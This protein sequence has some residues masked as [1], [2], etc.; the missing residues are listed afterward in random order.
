[1]FRIAEVRVTPILISDPPLL[2][3]QGVHQPVHAP[4]DRRG[5]HR[6]GAVGLGET[7]GTPTTCG[8]PRRSARTWSARRWWST[9]CWPRCWPPPSGLR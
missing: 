9:G 5:G 2:N 7:Y 4:H 3:V 8:W 6:D 1:M